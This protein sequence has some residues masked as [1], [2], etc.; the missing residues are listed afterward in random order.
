MSRLVSNT[1]DILIARTR[2]TVNYSVPEDFATELLGI[3]Q[4]IINIALKEITVTATFNTTADT[5]LYSVKTDL[6]S[7]A[8]DIVSI[9]RSTRGELDYVKSLEDLSAY[10][11]DWFSA[12]DADE[13]LAWAK[14]GRDYFII[15]P[16]KGGASSVSV[17]YVKETTIY[18][19]YSALTTETMEVSDES[20]ELVLKLAEA[21]LLIRS[22]NTEVLGLT[23]DS[24]TSL[25]ESKLNV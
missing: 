22:R 11:I 17:V 12:T 1:V 15:Y 6:S 13:F 10:D 24:L 18:T 9:S 23:V 8:C 19:D 21:L 14:V 3:C 4:Q 16:A 25:F 5:Q 7:S 2:Q 20:V